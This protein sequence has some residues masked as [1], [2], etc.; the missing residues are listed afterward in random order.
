MPKP[1][2]D[3]VQTLEELAQ[4]LQ[5]LEDRC[6]NANRQLT[7]VRKLVDRLGSEFEEQI[8]LAERRGYA[9]RKKPKAAKSVTGYTIEPSRK[10]PALAEHRSTGAAAFHCPKFAYD[11][12]AKVISSG[13]ESQKFEEIYERVAT[14]MGYEP[15]VYWV[16]VATRYFCE[17][18][19]LKH[20]RARFVRS[21]TI[22]VLTETKRAWNLLAAGEN[23]T[24]NN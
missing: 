11:A 6:P 17:I 12:V 21:R 5:K 10:G 18:D 14:V 23:R 13:P 15:P 3:P 19:L 1:K 7:A 16:R 22:G 2:G 24:L 4:A 8:R 20:A 9:P